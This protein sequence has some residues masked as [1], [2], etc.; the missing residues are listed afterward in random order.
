M[1]SSGLPRRCTLRSM[2]S[3]RNRLVKWAQH[4][5]P[6]RRARLMLTGSTTV[7]LLLAGCSS[8][9]NPAS[10][11]T[12]TPTVTES[13][14][15]PSATAPSAPGSALSKPVHFTFKDEQGWSWELTA[16]VLPIVDAQVDVSDSPPGRAQVKYTLASTVD[17]SLR[18]L[19]QG[20]TPP[21]SFFRVEYKYGDMKEAPGGDVHDTFFSCRGPNSY[22]SYADNRLTCSTVAWISNNEGARNGKPYWAPGSP[23]ASASAAAF[24]ASAESEET[25]EALA[26]ATVAGFA[27]SNL[28][29]VLL[30]VLCPFE[31]DAATGKVTLQTDNYS[32]KCTVLSQ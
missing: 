16:D 15:A 27:P 9:A 31:I 32:G 12:S 4:A 8:T 6:R 29:T 24:G 5:Q 26:K 20:R 14:P 18:S 25:S 23:S 1:P 19:D 28:K 22:G 7:V 30:S 21:D 10:S 17:A 3:D 11:P 13:V 2:I